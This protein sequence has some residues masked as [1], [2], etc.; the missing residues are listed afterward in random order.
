VVCDGL[1]GVVF[2]GTIDGVFD[3]VVGVVFDGAM[4]VYVFHG[5]C[6]SFVGIASRSPFDILTMVP[7]LSSNV[8]MAFGN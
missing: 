1:V 7:S 8:S 5:V 6:D 2:D 4:G 3:G